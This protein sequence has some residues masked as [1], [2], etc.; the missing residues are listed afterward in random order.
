MGRS[1]YPDSLSGLVTNGCFPFTDLIAPLNRFWADPTLM[2][3]QGKQEENISKKRLITWRHYFC[4]Q[5]SY[6][7]PRLYID[8]QNGVNRSIYATP[9]QR[10]TPAKICKIQF[11][12]FHWRPGCTRN[13]CKFILFFAVLPSNDNINRITCH[14]AS[15]GWKN[16]RLWRPGENKQA[17]VKDG[18]RCVNGQ[19][20]LSL[21][22][23]FWDNRKNKER[24]VTVWTTT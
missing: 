4:Y 14:E 8:P 6:F 16:M 21:L 1:C 19:V 24:G 11:L 10:A 23:L 7:Q 17:G 15:M 18:E 9:G 3:C 20:A 13:C 5:N 22:A 12:F 2:G